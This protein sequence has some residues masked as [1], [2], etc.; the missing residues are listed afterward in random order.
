MLTTLKR[1]I[2]SGLISFRRQLGLSIATTFILVM[3][4]SLITLLFLFQK[5]TLF[6]ISQ[7]QEEANISVYFKKNIQEEDILKIKE[8]IIKVPEVNEVVYISHQEALEEFLRKNPELQ[9]SVEI[10]Q[11]LLNL[12]SLN[13]KA[14]GIAQYTAISDF[15]ENS[16]F[17]DSVQKID[18]YQRKPVIERIFA[19]TSTIKKAGIGLS[20]ILAIASFLIAFN[21]IK[22]AIFN[23]RE[24]IAV[25][26]LVGASNWFIRG[27]FIVQGIVSGFLAIFIT[28]FV[29]FP[30]IFFLTPE[31]EIL[32][33]EL[34]LF[35]L[36]ISNFFSIFLLQFF[37]GIGLS[38]FSSLIAM[39]KYLKI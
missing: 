22:L 10:T 1:I 29:F 11:G 14:A 18:Y 20:I 13:I 19:F 9:E 3:T 25:Q 36:F 12:A 35:K 23:F 27:P 24:E 30:L 38:V 26:R 15:L 31:L 17:R 39:R 16:P 2:R 28:I 4:I 7:L 33:P 5:T 32:I 34:N 21:Q 37:V 6:L 8:E